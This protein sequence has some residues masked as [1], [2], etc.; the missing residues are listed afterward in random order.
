MTTTLTRIQLLSKSGTSLAGTDP[1]LLD[2]EL[3]I[4][5]SGG[6]LPTIKIGDGVR[7]WSALPAL[8]SD[9]PDYV[10]GPTVTLPPGS[11]AT[12]VIDNVAVPPTISFGIPAARTVRRRPPGLIPIFNSATADHSAAMRDGRSRKRPARSRSIPARWS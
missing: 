3:A 5:D 4:A 12:V 7:H 1:V 11:A 9:A 8:M 6:S 2:G 10:A